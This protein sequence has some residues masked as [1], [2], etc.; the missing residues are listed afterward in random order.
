MQDFPRICPIV[1]GFGDQKD[2]QKCVE[3]LIAQK[4]VEILK[5]IVVQNGAS[6]DSMASLERTFSNVLVIRNVKNEGAATGRNIAIR[7]S[8][9]FNPDFFFFADNDAIFDNH[10]IISLVKAS[11]ENPDAG[12]LSCLVLRKSHPEKI[13][14]AGGFVVPPLGAIH[15]YT[16]NTTLSSWN[17]DFA[18]SIGMLFP[19]RTVKVIGLMDDRLFVYDEDLEWCLRAKKAGLNTL[20]VRDAL[21]YHDITA[22]KM[23][24]PKRLYYGQRNRLFVYNQY[25]YFDSISEPK[26]INQL[27]DGLG[28]TIFGGQGDLSITGAGAY[29]FA[30]FDFARKR[31]GSCPKMFERENTHY[32]EY[33]LWVY[34]RRTLLFTLLKNTYRKGRNLWHMISS[35]DDKK[36]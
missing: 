34:L 33:K 32:L 3:S 23:Q 19:I 8:V 17:V 1:L 29:L 11:K 22:G 28:K 27:V 18:P 25:G 36:I 31:Y 20:I 24:S 10:A 4:D 2:M 30:I 26:I 9:K 16:I 5:I 6:E 14:S 15:I 35:K 7:A 13:F 12:L 21:A